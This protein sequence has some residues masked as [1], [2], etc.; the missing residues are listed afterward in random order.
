M[1]SGLHGRIFR[2]TRP[3]TCPHLRALPGL[4]RPASALTGL[5]GAPCFSPYP[6]VRALLGLGRPAA[7]LLAHRLRWAA[8]TLCWS[9]YRGCQEHLTY[10]GRFF[11]TWCSPYRSLGCASR[12]ASRVRR[13][14]ALGRLYKSQTSTLGG[15]GMAVPDVNGT[16]IKTKT[17]ASS[18]NAP[19]RFSLFRGR[20]KGE[21]RS[22]GLVCALCARPASLEVYNVT[23]ATRFALSRPY[24][25]TT[26]RG[27]TS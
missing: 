24:D 10:I 15:Y 20:A 21:A 27:L 8:Y 22:S 16:A 13:E 26:W 18:A 4:G 2:N 3:L 23:R 1:L 17:T 14:P 25:A 12:R 6:Q 19:T 5:P 7:A 9:P 11:I